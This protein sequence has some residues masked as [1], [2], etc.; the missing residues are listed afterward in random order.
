MTPLLSPKDAIEYLLRHGEKM[1]PSR[2]RELS[3]DGSIKSTATGGGHRRYTEQNLR[4]YLQSLNYTASW[5]S[6]SPHLPSLAVP[7]HSVERYR[8]KAFVEISLKSTTPILALSE[9]IEFMRKRPEVNHIILGAPS[10]STI[11]TVAPALLAAADELGV[12]V[13]FEARN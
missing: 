11:S 5:V 4:D 13:T 12:T 10:L 3:A 9:L 1:S 6:E 7:V 8:A 2:L